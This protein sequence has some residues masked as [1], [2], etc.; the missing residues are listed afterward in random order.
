MTPEDKEEIK[1]DIQKKIEELKTRIADLEDS[2]KPIAPDKALGR[3]TRLDAMQAKAVREAGLALCRQELQAVEQQ[4]LII[5]TPGFGICRFCKGEIGI[6]RLKA[7]PG[8]A[9][10][11]K[12]AGK[13]F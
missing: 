4:L 2:T 7:L 12:C 9:R 10:C 6:K 3:L 11:I 13:H 8:T 1:K 5:D